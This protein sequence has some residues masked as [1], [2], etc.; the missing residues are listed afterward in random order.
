MPGVRV[1][2]PTHEGGHAS[3]LVEW[4][5]GAIRSPEGRAVWRTPSGDRVLG[6][7]ERS[8]FV[9]AAACLADQ[10]WEDAGHPDSDSDAAP[11]GVA[12]FDRLDSLAR[13]TLLWD[14]VQG[15][16]DP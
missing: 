6:G 3:R 7:K 15:L 12:L 14:V 9:H 13:V 8:L 10:L 11:T 2:L 5:A 1:P 16:T 4:E